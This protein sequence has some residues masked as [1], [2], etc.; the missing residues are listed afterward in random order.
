MAMEHW[1]SY[2]LFEIMNDGDSVDGQDMSYASGDA[3]LTGGAL[4]NGTGGAGINHTMDSP[5]FSGGGF[6]QGVFG[7]PFDNGDTDGAAQYNAER[8][9]EFDTDM[10]IFE[11]TTTGNTEQGGASD[12]PWFDEDDM[13][14]NGALP[15]L[16]LGQFGMW[17]EDVAWR[18]PTDTA[19]LGGHSGN[20]VIDSGNE[21]M[22]ALVKVLH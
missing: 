3:S 4:D 2:N 11:H 21:C 10:A 22:P 5:L 6:G 8:A 9:P 20:H 18:C 17:E 12:A 13:I 14:S 16:D 15:P 1:D 19:A 7:M